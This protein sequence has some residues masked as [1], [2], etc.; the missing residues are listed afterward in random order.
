M[1][2]VAGQEHDAI[3]AEQRDLVKAAELCSW[4]TNPSLLLS[5]VAPT[6]HPPVSRLFSTWKH[7]QAHMELRKIIENLMVFLQ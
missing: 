7:Q 4:L 1:A 2:V 3:L 5:L 6:P